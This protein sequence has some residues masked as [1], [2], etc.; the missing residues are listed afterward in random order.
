MI[1][2]LDTQFGRRVQQ[3]GVVNDTTW[4][5]TAGLGGVVQAASFP[6]A[7]ETRHSARY[8]NHVGDFPS[9]PEGLHEIDFDE[10]SFYV[11]FYKITIPI[12]FS[13]VAVIGLA[14]NALVIYVVLSRVDMRRNAVNLL[15]L[16]LA[17]RSV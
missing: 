9:T 3:I 7:N 14:G 1:Q 2:A 8:G 12:L 6:V 13:I 11:I 10:L 4:L 17:A 5:A 15:L 16:N